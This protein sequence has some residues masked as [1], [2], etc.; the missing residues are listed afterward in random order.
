MKTPTK[1][2]EN[3]TVPPRRAPRERKSPAA[4]AVTGLRTLLRELSADNGIAVLT[5]T[6]RRFHD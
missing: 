6:L 4:A 3:K 5:P 2:R 1:V